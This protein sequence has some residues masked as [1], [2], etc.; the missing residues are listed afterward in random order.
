MK[1]KTANLIFVP[2][3]LLE[4]EI[5][6]DLKMG[7][8]MA[9]CWIRRFGSFDGYFNGNM[10]YIFKTYGLHYDESKTR[11]L[12]KQGSLFIKGLDYLRNIGAISLLE[13][14]YNDIH[15]FFVIKSSL[16]TFEKKYVSLSFD[17]FDYLFSIKK[18]INKMGLLYILL[19]VL[20]GYVTKINEDGTK[21]YYRSC[22]Y[23]LDGFSKKTGLN[24]MTIYSYLK[25]LSIEEG[26]EGKAPLIKSRLWHIKINGKIIRFPNIYV[27]NLSNY[28]DVIKLQRLALK[29]R[30]EKNNYIENSYNSIF[31]DYA[32]FDE[33]ELY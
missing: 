22:S 32:D 16:E 11:K 10:Q 31:D 23:S 9:F 4:K 12:P 21:E 3:E 33:T 20:S 25:N 6:S 7:T 13:G 30:F 18:R 2:R 28:Q 26:Y 24:K 14:D 8:L 17:Y 19:I 5:N 15:S 27:E 29:S 1:S